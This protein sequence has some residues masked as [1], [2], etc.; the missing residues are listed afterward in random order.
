MI[1]RLLEPGSKELPECQCGETMTLTRT[2]TAS[3]DTSRKIFH[4]DACGREMRLM[5]WMDSAA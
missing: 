2:E 4:C 3:S 1:E 5:V